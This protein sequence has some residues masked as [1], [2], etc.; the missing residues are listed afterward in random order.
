MVVSKDRI[1]EVLNKIPKKVLSA[2]TSIR[3]QQAYMVCSRSGR[4]LQ[5]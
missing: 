5:E 1:E 3:S 4:M 2:A